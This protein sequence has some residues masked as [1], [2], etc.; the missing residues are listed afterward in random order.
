MPEALNRL[1]YGDNLDVL[2]RHIASE[3]VD[4]IYLDP[5]FNSNAD[6][7]AFFAEQDGSRAAAQI[8]AFQDTWEWNAESSRSYFEFITDQQTP[9][10]ARKA[11]IAFRDLLGDSNML[12]YL[13]M[14]APRLVELR[15]VLR[16]TGSL[17]LHCDPTASHYLK[18]LLDGVFGLNAF[19]S[20]VIW[21]RTGAH[22]SAKRYG[23]VHD[24]ILYYTK[25][26]ECIWNVQ[27]QTL[28]TETAD[29]WYN[30]VEPGT[31]RRFNR[32]NLTAAGTRSGS[33]GMPWRG[34]N[35]TAKGRHWAIPGF[36]R[37][38][39]GEKDTIEA[40]DALDAMGR[41]YWPQKDG[42]MPMVKRY[43]EESKGVP[44][45][46]V[47]TDIPPLKNNIPERLGY[48]TQKPVTLLE[49]ILLSSS[50]PGDVVLDPFCG[51]GTTIAAAQKL[52]RQWVG[53]DV[54]SLA[55]TLIKK[56]LRD[57][58]GPEITKTYKVIGEPT[59]VEDA[60][61]LAEDDPYQ[62]Q[63]WVLGLVDARPLEE[64]KGADR[65]IDG[66][67]YFHDDAESGATKQ[68]VFS[69]KAGKSLGVAMVRDLGHVV[70]REKAAIG[71]LLTMH[72]P[73]GPMK[74]EAAG[75]GIYTS[76]WDRKNYPRLQ[77]VTVADLLAGKGVAMPPSQDVRTFKKAA[78]VKRSGDK[79]GSLFDV[80]P[81]KN[82]PE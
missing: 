24:T 44:I 36:L 31:G 64:K 71:V 39:V 19:R 76:P 66:R 28:P 74:A 73:T 46:D 65:G 47:I 34:I 80:D 81:T 50:N 13:S 6:Y 9:D 37:A 48:P 69:V 57:E 25:T 43:L 38:L 41:I 16:L 40:L 62:F 59:T 10:R 26:D 33:S 18:I 51:C 42:G 45:Q 75:A 82:R 17:Y 56:R 14:M 70:E 8:K 72:E 63:W 55:T 20:E 4:L 79:T 61:K 35:P 27:Y 49:R 23:P 32:D 54:T 1:Y 30:N 67:L 68:V 22:N 29:Q 52:G 21:K 12:A 11:L 58:Y 3:S 60:R 53:I 15:R 2:R 78:R 7:N 77:L 5:P